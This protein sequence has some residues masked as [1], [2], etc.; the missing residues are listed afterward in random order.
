MQLYD[1]IYYYS[2]SYKKLNTNLVLNKY[3]FHP[4]YLN[5]LHCMNSRH[6]IHQNFA[7]SEVIYDKRIDF[8]DWLTYYVDEYVYM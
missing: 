2:E 1:S 6:K 7:T 3:L 5:H 8:C 4:P